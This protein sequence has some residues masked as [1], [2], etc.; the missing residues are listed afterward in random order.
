M[1]KKILS[2]I[3][4]EG[5][6]PPLPDIVTRIREMTQSLNSNIKDIAKII[7]IDPVLALSIIKLSNSVYYSRST[8]QI[9][10]LPLAI[11]KIG[12]NMLVKLVYSLKLC[13]LFTESS[14]LS[15]SQFWLHSLAVAIFSQSL[16]RKIKAPQEE[17][18]ITY[19]AGLMHDIGIMAFGYLAPLEY[20]DFLTNVREKDGPLVTLEKNAFGIDHAELGALYIE[21]WWDVDE[22]ITH[23]VR[24][25]HEPFNGQTHISTSVQLV[26]IANNICNN[27]GITN[28]IN[29]LPEEFN[30]EEALTNLGLSQDEIENIL[31]DVQTALD[32]AKELVGHSL[33]G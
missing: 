7:E 24:Y 13:P 18:D 8:T 20:D 29:C 1:R 5:E 27:Q 6:L 16:S 32:Q 21:R 10:T 30:G 26:N 33:S 2:L 28:G 9:K 23:A 31:E 3:D 15:N 22:N 14:F 12:L 4:I 25:H 17:Q 19:L 11:T